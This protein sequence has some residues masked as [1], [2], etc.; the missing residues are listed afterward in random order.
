MIVQILYAQIRIHEC[1]GLLPMR[2]VNQMVQPY[3]FSILMTIQLILICA[4]FVAAIWLLISL[5]KCLFLYYTKIISKFIGFHLNTFYT[6]YIT[7]LKQKIF[8]TASELKLEACVWFG[9][10]TH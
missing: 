1:H 6:E 10:K 5:L 7:K 2:S 8:V 4:I 3:K 9:H